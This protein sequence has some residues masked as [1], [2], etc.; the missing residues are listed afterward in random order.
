MK[1]KICAL[2]AIVLFAALAVI[3]F[4]PEAELLKF[5]PPLWVRYRIAGPLLVLALSGIFLLPWQMTLAMSFSFL[6]DF[7]GAYGSFIGQMGFFALAHVMMITFF[8]TRF[9]KMYFPA[10][11]GYA[12]SSVNKGNIRKSM[13]V[14]GIVAVALMAFALICIVPYAPAGVIRTGCGIYAILICLM[15]ASALVQ[16]D[17]L[18]AAGAA[19]FLF[20]DMILS[21]NRFVTPIE[22]STYLIMIPYYL[23]QLLLW[24]ESARL[25]DFPYKIEAV[26]K[27]END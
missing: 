12:E 25:S 19:L 9:R 7:M 10:K 1:K 4:I 17:P 5:L 8:L 27:R 20:S 22:G 15:L 26:A 18:L 14:A 16:R 23:G 6:G 11:S 2:S 13:A 21:W 24:A 3:Y